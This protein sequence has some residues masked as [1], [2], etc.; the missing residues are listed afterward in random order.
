[1]VI[2]GFH[3]WHSS[4]WRA[5]RRS[6]TVPFF[7]WA[8]ERRRRRL[9]RR[10]HADL[11]SLL[12]SIHL[13][14]STCQ[15]SPSSPL[16]PAVGP[17]EALDGRR[18]DTTRKICCCWRHRP[19]GRPSCALRRPEQRLDTLGAG[20]RHRTCGGGPPGTVLMLPFAPAAGDS[21]GAEASIAGGPRGR[22]GQT[23]NWAARRWSYWPNHRRAA[24]H[25]QPH[26]Q[27]GAPPTE[28]RPPAA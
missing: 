19:P 15:W 14:W 6:S 17:D 1:M 11:C 20:R 26:H 8:D 10:P 25:H 13:V 21:A 23:L 16:S 7:C 22:N 27:Q 2:I 24:R 12:L 5:R 4:C 18:R 28:A 9:R 3:L